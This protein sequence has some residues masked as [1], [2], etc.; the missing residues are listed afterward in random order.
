MAHDSHN[1]IAAGVS[2]D[3]I[4]SAVNEI[5]KLEGGMVLVRGGEVIASIPLPIAGLMSDLSGE[6]LRDKLDDLH[7]KAHAELGINDDAN[8][9]VATR[10]TRNKADDARALRL[11]KIRFHSD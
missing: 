5:I 8:V 9:Y 6:E 1:I 10:H 3:E 7:D 2:D 4:F 11:R